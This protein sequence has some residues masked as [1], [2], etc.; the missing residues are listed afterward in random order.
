MRSQPVT[1]SH[2]EPSRDTSRY[3]WAGLAP[4][5][6]RPSIVAGAH[7][8]EASVVI[9]RRMAEVW[10]FIIKAKSLL[11][12][13]PGVV[14]ASQTTDGPFSV[15]TKFRVSSRF[16]L[17]R[18]DW[19]AEVAETNPPYSSVFRS[20]QGTV[21]FVSKTTLEEVATGT[22][23]TS[24]VQFESGFGAAFGGVSD[25]I[26]TRVYTRGLQASLHNLADVLD[27]DSRGGLTNRQNEVLALVQQ[28]FTDAEIAAHLTLSS[29]TVGHHV[30]AILTA[31]QVPNRRALSRG[32]RVP[33]AAG[34]RPDDH[35]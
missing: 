18:Q 13:S 31:L 21:A 4:D 19:V 15:G 9:F 22:R 3:L 20:T 16:L 34:R 25:S 6:A 1:A 29:K 23:F 35:A 8:C 5:A 33:S 11:I 24:T 2:W 28:G 14:E 7:V 17:A 30:S 26:A 32:L 27:S 10:D 12:W